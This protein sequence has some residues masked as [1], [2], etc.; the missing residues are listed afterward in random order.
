MTREILYSL[1]EERFAL[2]VAGPEDVPGSMGYDFYF[3]KFNSPQLGDLRNE[4]MVD[5]WV[6]GDFLTIEEAFPGLTVEQL[7]EQW[8]VE[9]GEKFDE[10]QIFRAF[11]IRLELFLSLNFEGDFTPEEIGKSLEIEYSFGS[12]EQLK[13][14]STYSCYAG[15]VE[16]LDSCMDRK[17]EGQ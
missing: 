11:K 6:L 15:S 16:E 7:T 17:Y 2:A 9:S 12:V 1:H 3:E 14:A 8:E 5:H 4:V 13:L 10:D